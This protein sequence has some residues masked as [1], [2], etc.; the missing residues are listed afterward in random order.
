M[1]TTSRLS[2]QQCEA[3]YLSY[4]Q[5]LMAAS[6]NDVISSVTCIAR[7]GTIDGEG[8]FQLVGITGAQ[9]T[10]DF[11]DQVDDLPL[12]ALCVSAPR[13]REHEMGCGYQVVELHLI[14]LTSVDEKDGGGNVV[15]SAN[16]GTRFGFIAQAMSEDNYATALAAI[17]EPESGPDNR[18]VKNFR[19]FGFYMT[20]DMGQE[21]ARHWIDH[22][23][24]EVHCVPTDDTS[25]TQWG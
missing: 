7:N 10:D 18:A 21:S 14:L 22:L 6:G 24:F 5:A 15:A 9:A 17:N 8:N 2:R 16:A 11:N 20:E 12:P 3:V 4:L 19:A 23:V 1:S 25:A 13:S